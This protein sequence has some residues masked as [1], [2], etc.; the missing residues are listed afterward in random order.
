MGY[1]KDNFKDNV[2]LPNM[3]PYMKDIVSTFQGYTVARSDMSWAQNMK[4][5]ANWIAKLQRGESQY[6]PGYV[7]AYTLRMS[8]SMIG[9][10]MNSILRDLEAVIDEVAAVNTRTEYSN[11]KLKYA[12]D[13]K[14][15]LKMYARMIVE[16]GDSGNTKLAETIWNDLLNA[17]WTEKDISDKINSIMNTEIKNTVDIIGAAEKYS[18]TD[19]ESQ[20]YFQEQ[21]EKYIELK[22]K[23]GWDEAKCLKQIRSMLNEKYKPIWQQAKTQKEKEEIRKKCVQLYYKGD[24]IY[25][26]YN[27]NN[28]KE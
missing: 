16:A 14:D 19:K 12:I 28:W 2:F 25:A 6:T 10:P 9:V 11:A 20:K 15:N 23:A 17:G 3:V 22:K 24:S 21:V 8:S 26:G 27:F 4:Y 18:V 7:M 13:S 5:A 1:V